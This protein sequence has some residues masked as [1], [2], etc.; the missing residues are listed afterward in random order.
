MSLYESF[1]FSDR[2]QKNLFLLTPKPSDSFIYRASLM[3]NSV[4]QKLN[5]VD[6]S[7][8]V[9]SLKNRLHKFLL[10]KQFE[11]PTETWIEQ[12]FM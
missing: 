3:W 10:E 11:G 12:N 8:P 4:R 6:S 9:S 1:N 5:I 7:T 2:P